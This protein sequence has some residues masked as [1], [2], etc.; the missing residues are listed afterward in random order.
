ML[1]VLICRF[2]RELDF[3][4]PSISFII[5]L[6]LKEYSVLLILFCSGDEI[7]GQIDGFPNYPNYICHIKVLKILCL[8]SSKLCH[9]NHLTK[10]SS[11][12]TS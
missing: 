6:F 8:A 2:L 1:M 4:H 12:K 11:L 10:I 7:Y 5:L 9:Q 3:C